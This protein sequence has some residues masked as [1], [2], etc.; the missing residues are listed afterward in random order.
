MCYRLQWDLGHYNPS[1]HR[2]MYDLKLIHILK[3]IK[4][5]NSNT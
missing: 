4:D 2:N 5:P 3:K 1:E